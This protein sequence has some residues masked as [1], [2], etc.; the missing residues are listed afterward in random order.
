MAEG[1]FARMVESR[2]DFIVES[3]GVSAMDGQRASNHT[4]EALRSDRIDLGHFRSQGITRDLV[5]EATHIFCMTR[6]HLEAVEMLFPRA[7]D[8]TYLVTEFCPDDSLRGADIPDPIGLSRRAYEETREALKRSLPS[9][10][11]YI[12]T[13]WKENL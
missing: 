6:G 1:L 12:D 9:V 5:N 7:A 13:T 8:K 11:A 10:L 3:A 2:P 4:L